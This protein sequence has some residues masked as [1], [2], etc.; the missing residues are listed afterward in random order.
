MDLPAD[1]VDL[2]HH[3]CYR[4]VMETKSPQKVSDK[5]NLLSQISEIADK[6]V[7][8]RGLL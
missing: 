3:F 8:L 1:G 4:F 6:V 2:A 5:K 7:N